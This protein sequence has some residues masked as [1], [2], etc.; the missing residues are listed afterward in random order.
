MDSVKLYCYAG[1]MENDVIRITGKDP[2]EL[3]LELSVDDAQRVG[4]ATV[5]ARSLPNYAIGPIVRITDLTDGREYSV[6]SAPCGLGCHCAA[7]AAPVT[8]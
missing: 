5:S 3:V 1:E 8:S 6:A 2:H 4:D 7:V